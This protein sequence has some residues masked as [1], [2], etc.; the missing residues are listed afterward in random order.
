MITLLSKIFIK[1]RD[2]TGDQKVRRSYGILAS[3]VGICLN[4]L[5]FLG[6]YLA[7]AQ[8]GSIAI[9]SDAFNNLSDAGSSLVTLIGFKFAGMKPDADHP[10]GHGRIEYISG[11][12]VSATIILMGFEL[13]KSS[14]EKIMN[15]EPIDTSILSI[16]ILIAS[17][18]VKLY[19]NFYNR[20]IAKKIGSAACYGYG[21]LKRRHCNYGCFGIRSHRSFYRR[22]YR[23]LVRCCRGVLYSIRRL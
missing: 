11:F 12:I 16:G 18:C 5:L 9:M 3:V 15:P 23:W 10:F 2:N 4:I 6:K 8:C 13:G 7:G 21:Q 1:N 19:M 14:I 20:R 22:Q 17:I